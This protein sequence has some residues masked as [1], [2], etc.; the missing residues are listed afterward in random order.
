M[1][2]GI[3]EQQVWEAADRLLRDGE[4][5]TVEKIRQHIGSGSPNTVGPMLKNWFG[6]LSKRLSH[7]GP[8]AVS[9]GTIPQDVVTTMEAL[10]V[11]AMEAA[12]A[13]TAS[14]YSGLQ[15]AIDERSAELEER[16]RAL[17]S[18]QDRLSAREAD[19]QAAIADATRQA[20]QA[21]G[22]LRAAEQQ[23]A[24]RDRALEEAIS[25][26]R[27]ARVRADEA[28]VA[29]QM[30][31]ERHKGEMD[32]ATARHVAHERKM[33]KEIDEHRQK[34]DE[35]VRLTAKQHQAAQ[36]ELAERNAALVAAQSEIRALNLQLKA[37]KTSHELELESLRKEQS[38]AQ[39][40][41]VNREQETRELLNDARSQLARKDEQ[42]STLMAALERALEKHGANVEEGAKPRS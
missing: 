32:G 38:D 19:L 3:T 18:A 13:A 15:V 16:E 41:L 23:L 25:Q 20:A 29:L 17:L 42:I 1:A 35:C 21:E 11:H 5:P 27:S 22:R 33:L 36:K 30:A 34:L 6:G 37:A 2:R 24:A 12:R 8:E 28:V 4:Q 26:E 9:A 39:S 40:R 14:E 10:W 31:L 7:L